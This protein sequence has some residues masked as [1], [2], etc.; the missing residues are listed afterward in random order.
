MNI[1]GN[2]DLDPVEKNIIS[3]TKEL[4][5]C[6]KEKDGKMKIIVENE[7]MLSCEVVQQKLIEVGVAIKRYREKLKTCVTKISTVKDNFNAI[8]NSRSKAKAE[9]AFWADDDLQRA[10]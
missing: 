1:N 3:R 2:K 10:K 8:I 7:A 6:F 5:I 4:N 9:V